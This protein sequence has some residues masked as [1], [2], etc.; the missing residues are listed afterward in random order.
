MRLGV[1]FP[2][3]GIGNDP[4]FIKDYAVA[5][6]GAGYD[7]LTVYDHVTGSPPERFDSSRLPFP[8][9]AYT[10][11]SPFHEPFVLYG[12]LAAVTRTLELVTGVLVAPQRQTVLIAKQAAAL[13]V[14][15]GGRLRLGVGLGWNY[16]EYEALNED[17]HTRGRRLD[18][19]ITLMRRLWTA[20]LVSFEG[21]WHHIDRVGINPLPVQRPIPVWLGG[22]AEAM[23]QRVGRLGDGWFPQFVPSPEGKATLERLHGYI[24][25]AGRDP[26]AVG[27]EARMSL[28][29]ADPAR[30][31]E[32]AR[33]WREVG[34]TH[35]S[36]SMLGSGLASP[37][38]HLRAALAFRQA[39]YA[40]GL[41]R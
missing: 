31:V 13:D 35:L 23:V 16:T 3:N 15:S 27:I 5:L 25:A 17:F 39:A 18:E 32:R 11:Q 40:E 20:P 9:P 30:W 4:A 10:D 7:H 8:E 29:G 24:R 2:Q 38:E 28:R 1:I 6:E 41:D 21:R 36:V 34:A 22:S 14:L 19:Q 33:Q 37:A 26:A 12:F